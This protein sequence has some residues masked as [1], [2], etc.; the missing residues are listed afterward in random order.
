[1]EFSERKR[2]ARSGDTKRAICIRDISILP[3]L[4]ILFASFGCR[5]GSLGVVHACT[6]M[7][8]VCGCICVNINIHV[9]IYFRFVVQIVV[10]QSE[11]E[12][13]GAVRFKKQHGD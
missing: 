9:Y 1:L 3:T 2:A 6:G 10:R 12:R 13:G 8:D 4:Q 7:R 5:W 11:V